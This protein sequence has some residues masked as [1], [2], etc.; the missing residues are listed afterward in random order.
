MPVHFGSI[1]KGTE[2]ERNDL[3]KLW[4]YRSFHAI[5]RGVFTP[6]RQKIIVLFVTEDKQESATQYKDRLDGQTLY[7]EGEDGHRNDARIDSAE[8]NSDTIHIFYRERH[9]SPFKYLG[10]G[11]VKSSKI[12]SHQPSKFTFDLT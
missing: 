2:W 12:L 1:K 10:Q 11:H 9:H 3:A 5:A 6:A 8:E 7:W 4:G